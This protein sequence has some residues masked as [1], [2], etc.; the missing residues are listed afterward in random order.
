MKLEDGS[1]DKNWNKE[2][3]EGRCHLVAFAEIGMSNYSACCKSCYGIEEPEQ[4]IYAD[5]VNSADETGTLYPKANITILPRRFF[6]DRVPDGK[7]LRTAL[8]DA[9]VA[10]RDHVKSGLVILDFTGSDVSAAMIR[11]ICTELTAGEFKNLPGR[12]VLKL[13][14]PATRAGGQG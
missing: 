10:E 3:K 13:D 4:K 8:R 14:P 2:L 6:R 1:P 5:K 12:A 11:D 9:F 7:A